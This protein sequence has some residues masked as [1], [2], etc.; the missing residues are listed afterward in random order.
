M[1][2]KVAALKRVIDAYLAHMIAVTEDSTVKSAERQKIKGY[3]LKWRDSKILLGCAL[4]HDLLKPYSILCKVLQEVEICVVCAIEAVMKTKKSLEK[5][6]FC[7][8]K[9]FLILRKY[10]G[11]SSQKKTDHL[12]LHIKEQNSQR[13]TEL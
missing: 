6:D 12:Q 13:M 10:S 11:R 1:A 5:M 3:T 2:H 8:L 7:P 4:F 9:S